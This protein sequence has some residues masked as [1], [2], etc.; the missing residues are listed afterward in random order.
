SAAD[1]SLTFSYSSFGSRY[2]SNSPHSFSARALGVLFGA[3]T[4]ILV[5]L[6]M[7]GVFFS[8]WGLG[9]V[10]V[11]AINAYETFFGD[12]LRK[13]TMP[14]FYTDSVTFAYSD[15][16][17]AKRWWIEAFGCKV[18]KPPSDW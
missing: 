5:A 16:K 6:Y 2:G 14:L 8:P 3:M 4:A 7:V 1:V 12:H 9:A 13:A 10:T 11:T 17:S 18:A 15:V